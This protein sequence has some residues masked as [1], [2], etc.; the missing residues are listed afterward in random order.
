VSST[1]GLDAVALQGTLARGDA[2]VEA[3]IAETFERIDA[4]DAR[5]HVFLNTERAYAERRAA[6]LDRALAAGEEPGPLFGVPIALKANMCLEGFESSCGS[7]ILAG[8]RAPYTATFVQRLLDA[9]A[10]PIGTTNMDEFAMGSSSENSAF[11]ATRNPWDPSR[12]PGGSS[13]GSAVAVAA[14]LVPIALGSDTGGSVRQPAALCGI[15]GFKPTYGRV[16][17]YGL[18]AFGS[19]LDQVSPFARSVRDIELVMSVMSGTDR[20][21]S[22][23]L[24]E[25][26]LEPEA[27]RDPA[28]LAGLSVG[29]PKEYFPSSLEPGVRRVVEAALATLEKLGAKIVPV[30]LPHTEYAIA[31]YYV[32]ATAEA[33][34]NL[35]RYD[36]VRYGLRVEGDG[37][38]QGMFA[39]TREAGFGPEVKRR[40]LLGT[41]VL[42]AGYYEAWYGRALKAR[43]RLRQDFESAFESVDVIAGP[44]SPLAAFKLGEKADDPLAMYLADALTVPTSLSG[45]PAISVPCG[46]VEVDSTTL[47]VGMQLIGQYR[48]DARVLRV[49]RAFESATEFARARPAHGARA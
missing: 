5:L 1:S 30:S 15:H 14:G 4:V 19:S 36:G 27:P 2:G 46:T 39:A 9:G 43:A 38:L 11:G 34:S 8:Y 32:L 10:I 41:Y 17:R 45:L 35:A 26:P 44:T 25:P 16:S 24:D 40:I 47:P 49:A 20:N 18:I 13:S 3:T 42:S 6:D 48:S 29:V 22:T 33:S 21:D 31:T 23:C 37:S 7:K 12:T 28:S